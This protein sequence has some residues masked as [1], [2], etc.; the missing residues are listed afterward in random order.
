M[1][2]LRVFNH[3]SNCTLDA[4]GFEIVVLL[5]TIHFEELFSPLYC[6]LHATTTLFSI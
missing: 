5:F 1:H 2:R 6:L 4:L 3:M